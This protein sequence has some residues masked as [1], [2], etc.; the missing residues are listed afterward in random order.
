MTDTHRKKHPETLIVPTVIAAK[1]AEWGLETQKV[2]AA[3][4]HRVLEALVAEFG[5]EGAVVALNHQ[6]FRGEAYKYLLVPLCA[7]A[8]ARRARAAV[9][10]SP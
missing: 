1:A 3:D 6:G 10:R 4:A 7:E 2:A 5:V 9:R 8:V